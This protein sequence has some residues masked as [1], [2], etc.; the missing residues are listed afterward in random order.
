V[1]VTGAQRARALARARPAPRE[2]AAAQSLASDNYEFALDALRLLT[3]E[4]DR[5]YLGASASLREGLEET[6]T[7]TRLGIPGAAQDDATEDEPDRVD[8][9]DRPAHQP[10]REALA[11]R[12]HMPLRWTAAGMLEAEQQF[13]TIIGYADL[14]KLANAVERDLLTHR[15]AVHTTTTP[16]AATL[17]T[18]S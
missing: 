13:R 9:R 1:S 15:S 12:R 16:Q 3:G 18:I 2:I 8:D 7:L 4:L 5:S 14:P 17:A 10:Q 11:V 6:L